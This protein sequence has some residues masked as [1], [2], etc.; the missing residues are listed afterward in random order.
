MTS[1]LQIERLAVSA[2]DVG[3]L[4]DVIPVIFAGFRDYIPYDRIG[5]AFINSDGTI[6]AETGV[7][8]YGRI[9]LAP[10]FTLHV[11]E[12]TLGQLIENPNKELLSFEDAVKTIRK[13]SG[14]H[15]DPY[16]VDV[17]LSEIDRIRKVYER[18]KD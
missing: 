18:Y 3:T 15:F 12:T 11:N 9:L 17:F 1:E 7:I 4:E 14:S 2:I 13:N 8:D 5:I 16:V 6:R 10:G